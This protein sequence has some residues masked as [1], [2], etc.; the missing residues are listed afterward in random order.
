MPEAGKYRMYGKPVLLKPIMS[1][2]EKDYPKNSCYTADSPFPHKKDG[3]WLSIANII[4]WIRSSL[5]ILS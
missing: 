3:G 4:A 1:Y 2:E 5:L